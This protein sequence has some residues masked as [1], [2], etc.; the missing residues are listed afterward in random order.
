MVGIRYKNLGRPAQ[1][2]SESDAQ[3][4]GQIKVWIRLNHFLVLHTSTLTHRTLALHVVKVRYKNLQRYQL[5]IIIKT[6]P[7][8]MYKTTVD[9]EFCDM[10]FYEYEV[11][12]RSE[13]IS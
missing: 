4:I 7:T 11:K 12:K 3:L 10:R 13:R 8:I 2:N 1:A 5:Q 9:I 6:Q